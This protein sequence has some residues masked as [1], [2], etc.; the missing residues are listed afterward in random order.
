MHVKR[1]TASTKARAALAPNHID[2]PN[3]CLDVTDVQKK[4]L[5]IFQFPWTSKT[6]EPDLPKTPKYNWPFYQAF[7]DIYE[8]IAGDLINRIDEAREI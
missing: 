4:K 5:N 3:M 8:E 2:S 7:I 6:I 1:P